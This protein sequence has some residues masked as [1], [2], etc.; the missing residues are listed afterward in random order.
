MVLNEPWN[1]TALRSA[2]ARVNSSTTENTEAEADCGQV[3]VIAL[4]KLG[5]G[6][7]RGSGA[8]AGQATS[9]KF[10]DFR[11]SEAPLGHPR[12]TNRRGSSAAP[13]TCCGCHYRRFKNDRCLWRTRLPAIMAS[14]V[15]NPC[16]RGPNESQGPLRPTLTGRRLSGSVTNGCRTHQNQRLILA[17]L[18]L[19]NRKCAAWRSQHPLSLTGAVVLIKPRLIRALRA[20]RSSERAVF[21]PV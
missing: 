19:L 1:T 16:V 18:D 5:E 13:S 17:L 9:V 10:P 11:G 14:A 6:S 2:P 3:R 20:V 7:K 8:R 15:S 21:H 4:G 12:R